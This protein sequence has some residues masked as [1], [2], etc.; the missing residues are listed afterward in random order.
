MTMNTT[1]LQ[2]IQG[3][4]ESSP[5]S[6]NQQSDQRSN[7]KQHKRKE[8]RSEKREKIRSQSETKTNNIF[9]NCSPKPLVSERQTEI[10][11]PP[12]EERNHRINV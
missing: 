3:Q 4:G 8:E 5:S 6:I 11:H 2:R 10:Q 9:L 7:T 12:S 1:Q